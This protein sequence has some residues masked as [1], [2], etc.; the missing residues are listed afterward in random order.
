MAVVRDQDHRAGIVVDRLDQ[1]VAAVDVEMVGRLVEDQQMR[2]A[3]RS[4]A[5]AAAAPSRRPT[6]SRPWCRQSAP[7]K[8]MR[9]GAGADLRLP[10]H[11]AS[12]AHDDRRRCRRD[13]ARR[14][15]AARNSRPS[16]SAARVTLPSC[17]ASRPA[18][19]LTSVDLPLP[20]EPSSAM[21]SSLSMRSESLRSTGRP[22]S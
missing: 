5:P 9:A 19:S 17:G 2:A 8:P 15:G 22:G 21:R 12:A 7:E 13:R 4:R 14:A 11:R 20:F 16:A 10:A 6:A 18:I 1:R 3:R